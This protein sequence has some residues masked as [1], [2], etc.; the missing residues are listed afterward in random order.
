MKS[1]PNNTMGPRT[2]T[3]NVVNLNSSL[4]WWSET[5]L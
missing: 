1:E 5:F 4:S 2:T 3:E